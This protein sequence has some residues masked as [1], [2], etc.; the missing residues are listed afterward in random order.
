VNDSIKTAL[1]ADDPVAHDAELSAAEIEAVRR[2]IVSAASGTRS[3]GWLPGPLTVGAT[4]AVT[5]AIVVF[6]G[7]RREPPAVRDQVVAPASE[8]RQV[9]F[10]T[11]GG[12]RVI[13]VL[14]PNLDL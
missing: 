4:L 10:E 7:T 6:I 9:Q 12:T 11:P 13:W 3:A 8:P 1:K 14:N 5:L 2:R